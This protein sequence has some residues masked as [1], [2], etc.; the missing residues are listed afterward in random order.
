MADSTAS[1]TTPNIPHTKPQFFEVVSFGKFESLLAGKLPETFDIRSPQVE[2]IKKFLENDERKC[3]TIVVEYHY[4]DWAYIDEYQEFYSTSF[5]PYPNFCTRLHFFSEITDDSGR[6]VDLETGISDVL[7]VIETAEG[8]RIVY[9]EA[10]N[11]FSNDYYLG[12]MVIKPLPATRIGRTILR[13][14]RKSAETQE[15]IMFPCTRV[16]T[17]HLW[18]LDLSVCGLPFQ[19]QDGGMSACASTATWASLSHV[20]EFEP[21]RVPSPAAITKS[22]SHQMTNFGRSIPQETGLTS[23]QMCRAIEVAGL[24]PQII[25]L[26][27]LELY[28]CKALL[29]SAI[30]SGLAP[31]III[32]DEGDN[33]AVS[34]GGMIL[35]NDRPTTEVP[36]DNIS[37]RHESDFLDGIYINDD[38]YGPYQIARIADSGKL[39]IEVENR[40]WTVSHMIIP[41]SVKVRLG[42]IGLYEVAI[43]I[44][45]K[46]GSLS[47]G[48]ISSL[49]MEFWITPSVSYRKNSLFGT[50]RLD[51]NARD[52]L[53]RDV[54]LSRYVGVVRL[55]DDSFGMIDI[56]ID[57]TNTSRHT[58]ILFVLGRQIKNVDDETIVERLANSLDAS[59]QITS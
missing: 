44:A 5:K 40:S 34:V 2:R 11:R 46:I 33:H 51:P 10:C 16:Y 43:G 42:L 35:R 20:S 24:S 47:I 30:K 25:P 59:F 22:A 32:S 7:D 36:L 18:G 15:R 38:R 13:H 23:G 52:F 41:L 4:I 28:Q 14:P 50:K 21:F 57:V 17:S 56:V 29:H 3:V 19:E 6:T 1:Y 54:T 31:I 8:D 9:A 48:R 27:K 53:S 55:K 37:V 26:E 12:F 45:D 58:N 39:Y 49:S